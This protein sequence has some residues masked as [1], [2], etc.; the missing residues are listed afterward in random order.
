M[1]RVSFPFI[2]YVLFQNVLQERAQQ[3]KYKKQEAEQQLELKRAENELLRMAYD[4]NERL[5]AESDR[6]EAEAVKLYRDD[7]KKQIEYNKILRV[8]SIT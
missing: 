6:L 4:Q 2:H 1:F 5:Q 3:I 7:L 8:S